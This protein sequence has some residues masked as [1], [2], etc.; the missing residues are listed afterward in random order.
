VDGDGTLDNGLHHEHQSIPSRSITRTDCVDVYPLLL[1][2]SRVLILLQW[3][4]ARS[5]IACCHVFARICQPE[6]AQSQFWD[7]PHDYGRFAVWD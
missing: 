6:A 3:F 5:Q 7:N 2:L 4:R 1:S